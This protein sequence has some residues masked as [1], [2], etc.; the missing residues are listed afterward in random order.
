MVKIT[1]SNCN[2]SRPKSKDGKWISVEEGNWAGDFYLFCR[3]WCKE[4]KLGVATPNK[5]KDK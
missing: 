5:D 2:T 1:C 3:E 4:Q